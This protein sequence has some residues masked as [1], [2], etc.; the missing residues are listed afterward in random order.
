M[1]REPAIPG[2]HISDIVRRRD[3]PVEETTALHP[4]HNGKGT[5]KENKAS[6][7]ACTIAS[8]VPL[9]KSGLQ[10]LADRMRDVEGLS[11]PLHRAS[12]TNLMRSGVFKKQLQAVQSINTHGS[13]GSVAIPARHE[14]DKKDTDLLPPTNSK[15][16]LSPISHKTAAST[17]S[18][19][20]TQAA[21]VSPPVAVGT[22][23]HAKFMSA[24]A[25]EKAM[26]HGRIEEH[27]NAIAA[28]VREREEKQRQS[29]TNIKEASLKSD[30]TPHFKVVENAKTETLGKEKKH[31]SVSLA[32]KSV[33][34]SRNV[35]K[36]VSEPTEASRTSDVRKIAKS[37]APATR[38]RHRSDAEIRRPVTVHGVGNPR[39]KEFRDG[40]PVTRAL[41]F[42]DGSELIRLPVDA[43][44]RL[45]LRKYEAL[46]AAAEVGDLC[47]GY[48]DVLWDR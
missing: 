41:A 10:F 12:S 27:K 29:L 46:T 26:N 30:G 45:T 7:S 19:N 37:A 38:N 14:S 24:V 3:V 4:N 9:D 21:S 44:P 32:H 31:V 25:R 23:R 5:G 6:N 15:A 42:V 18:E 47:V 39:K 1:S 40:R 34:E 28:A 43:G 16:R 17:N 2:F 8:A 20:R 22:D 36:T 48:R 35:R 33:N 11:D 13:S